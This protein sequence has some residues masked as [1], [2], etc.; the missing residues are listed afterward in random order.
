[1]WGR[2][3]ARAAGLVPRRAPA[4]VFEVFDPRSGRVVLRTRWAGLARLLARR[5]GMDYAPEGSGH[6]TAGANG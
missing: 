2:R 5:W 3:L 1:M 4:A 6:I